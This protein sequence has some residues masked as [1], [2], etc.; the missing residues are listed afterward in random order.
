M[1]RFRRV[2]PG[3][4]P[5]LA[6][7]QMAQILP[8]NPVVLWSLTAPDRMAGSAQES[9]LLFWPREESVPEAGVAA[10]QGRL[11]FPS[12]ESSCSGLVSCSLQEARSAQAS[13]RAGLAGLSGRRAPRAVVPQWVPQACSG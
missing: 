2:T 5:L 3:L 4:H 13:P 11:E 10:P 6:E 1:K 7:V 8:P 12:A 9:M